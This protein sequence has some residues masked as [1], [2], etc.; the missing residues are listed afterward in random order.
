MTPEMNVA[1]IPTNDSPELITV[2]D[3]GRYLPSHPKQSTV[4]SWVNDNTIPHY[5]SGKT[6]LFR[7]QEIEAW[8]ERA[9]KYGSGDYWTKKRKYRDE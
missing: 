4:Y 7:R 8:V 3:L 2:K 6:V 1:P 9:Q 5:K